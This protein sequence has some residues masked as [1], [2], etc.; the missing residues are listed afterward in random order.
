MLLSEADDLV[1]HS[2][3]AVRRLPQRSPSFQVEKP[4]PSPLIQ[5]SHVRMLWLSSTMAGELTHGDSVA[6]AAQAHPTVD[7]VLTTIGQLRQIEKTNAAWYVRFALLLVGIGLS[8]IAFALFGGLNAQPELLKGIVSIGGVFIT[9]LG[10]FPLKE[11]VTRRDRI[12]IYDIMRQRVSED[13]ERVAE[14]HAQLE[15]LMWKRLEA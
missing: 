10:S 3:P 11:I 2:P 9:S 8:V 12:R 13:P 7:V 14:Y 15:R 5:A 4:A 1:E 6:A